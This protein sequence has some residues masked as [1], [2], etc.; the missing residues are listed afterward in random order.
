[1]FDVTIFDFLM[2]DVTMLDIREGCPITEKAPIAK[3]LF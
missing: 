2:S 3:N 1:M